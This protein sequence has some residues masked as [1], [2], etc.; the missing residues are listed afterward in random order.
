M[1]SQFY[2]KLIDN[3]TKWV[4]EKTS[5]N[6]DFFKELS[7][8]QQPPLLWIG[9]ADSRVPPN[10]IVGTDPGEIFVHNPKSTPLSSLR[11]IHRRNIFSLFAAEPLSTLAKCFKLL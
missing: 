6:P 9:C 2:K 3:N 4:Q 10:Q 5:E 8:G 11:T 1:A 7:K